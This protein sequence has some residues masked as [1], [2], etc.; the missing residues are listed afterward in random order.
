MRNKVLLIG[1]V[2]V[3][4]LV[5]GTLA[6]YFKWDVGSSSN[7]GELLPPKELFG[8]PFVP[9]LRGKWVLLA[10]DEAACDVECEK[11][12]YIMRQLR[13]AQGKDMD[14]VVRVWVVISGGAP[15]GE[16]LQA[17]EGTEVFHA[18]Y[19]FVRRFPGPQVDHI[20]LV[21]PL[22]NLMM[23]WPREGDPTRMLKDLQRLMK[24]AA[25]G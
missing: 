7:Y 24:V 10:F 21:D 6:Y 13:R 16:L 11:K 8:P 17:F 12:L 23:R 20:Y 18:G 14:R 1:L 4:P 3:A 25:S 2:C 22:G 9:R 15:R 19:A 5:L